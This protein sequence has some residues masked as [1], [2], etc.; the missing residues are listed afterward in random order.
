ME[1]YYTNK[2]GRINFYNN[3]LNI[4]IITVKI[5]LII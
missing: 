1:N 5:G 2:N 3:I 4:G